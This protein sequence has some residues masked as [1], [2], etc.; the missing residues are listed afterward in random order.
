MKP[1]AVLID[2]FPN[3]EVYPG[4]QENEAALSPAPQKSFAIYQVGGIPEHNLHPALR[5]AP[6]L[7]M[8][9]ANLPKEQ[10]LPLAEV[11][12]ASRGCVALIQMLADGRLDGDDLT[13][14]LELAKA[15]KG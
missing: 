5:I 9:I 6:A 10:A 1:E 15:V 2:L 14:F 3:A 12:R 13:P 11:A 7:M 4:R 8:A